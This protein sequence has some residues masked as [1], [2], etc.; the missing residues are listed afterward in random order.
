M[1]IEP[2]TPTTPSQPALE[3]RPVFEA[4]PDHER[5]NPF[6]RWLMHLGLPVGLSVAIHVLVLAG[7]SLYTFSERARAA[8]EIGDYEAGLMENPDDRMD[9][10]FQWSEEVTLDAPE[11]E[12][13]EQLDLSDFTR[14]EAFSEA[15]F[16]DTG[17]ALDDSGG[18]GLGL[19]EGRFSLLGTGEGAGGTGTGAFGSGMGGRG[20]RL[21]QAGVWDVSIRANKIVYVVDFSG[22]IIVAVDDL[23]RELKRS[24][25]RLRP[26]QAFNVIIFYSE[27][28]GNSGRFKS[29]SFAPTLQAVTT[30]SRKQFYT[31]LDSKSP[32]G[33]TEPLQSMKRALA[34]GPEAIFFFSDGYFD[35][36]VVNE[37]ARANRAAHASIVCFVFD[38]ILLGDNSGLPRETDGARR[39]RKIAEQSGGLVK[40]VTGKDLGGH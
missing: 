36:S 35:D 6:Y 1:S 8:I 10:A 22:S 25:S 29:E 9:D 30:E 24:I 33:E 39:L 37:I 31:W 3:L 11:V 13:L 28:T 20:D 19:G 2:D 15:D 27:G 26:T 40:I 18:D 5:R 7:A 21:G 14:V 32:R 12:T 17:S 4:A 38:E 23:K 34:L 16:G